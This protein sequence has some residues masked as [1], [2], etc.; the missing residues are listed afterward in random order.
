M[1]DNYKLFLKLFDQL[2]S[3]EDFNE[4]DQII[5]VLFKIF[6]F[7]TFLSKRLDAILKSEKFDEEYA[8]LLNLLPFYFFFLNGMQFIY[9]QR[10]AFNIIF[11]IK[12]KII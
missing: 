3:S 9:I 8:E 2:K 6:S 5:Y 7:D 11:N 10:L 1:K 4:T 12:K